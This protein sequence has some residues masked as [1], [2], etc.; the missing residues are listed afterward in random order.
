MRARHRLARRRAEP[1]TWGSRR[2]TI[3]R[4]AGARAKPVRATVRAMAR[5]KITIGTVAITAE[6]LD[7]PTA[8]AIRA[9]A[10]L[11]ISLSR[12]GL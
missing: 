12:G 1:E 2:V 10:R 4:A 7:T 6:L 8:R 9:M 5:L 11:K 3:R